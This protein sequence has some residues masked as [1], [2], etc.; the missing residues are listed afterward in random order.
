[1]V[2]EAAS[3]G[4]QLWLACK[5]G[6]HVKALELL[7]QVENYPSD[8]I[9]RDEALE[10]TDKKRNGILHVAC[11][12]NAEGLEE[13]KKLVVARLLGLGFILD[14]DN[15]DGVKCRDMCPKEFIKDVS[16]IEERRKRGGRGNSIYGEYRTFQ[17]VAEA[18]FMAIAAI[19]FKSKIK[20]SAFGQKLAAKRAAEAEKQAEVEA[21]AAQAAAMRE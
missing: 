12:S 18:G 5:C 11:A 17:N 14:D 2:A 21:F 8:S 19:K 16:Q 7:D 4:K 9:E 13:E 15:N 3:L 6:D 20:N 1:M 10:Y